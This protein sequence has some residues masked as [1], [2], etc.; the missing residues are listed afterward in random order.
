MGKKYVSFN[1]NLDGLV[2]E[3]RWYTL[4][5]GWN[6]EM[7]VIDRINKIN[8]TTKSGI[9]IS[10]AF[11]PLQEVI[12]QKKKNGL[13]VDTIKY[14]KVMPNYVFIKTKL[15]S[16]M[17]Q[18]IMNISGVSAIMCTSGIPSSIQEKDIEKMKG[19]KNIA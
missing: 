8:I 5:T 6:C 4:F 16:D 2:E 15:D 11:T 17:Y 10:E 12:V 3:E 18:L 13:M 7:D 14:E 19:I 9:K 1:I